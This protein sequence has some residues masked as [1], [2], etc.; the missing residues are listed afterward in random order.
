[1]RSS[2]LSFLVGFLAFLLDIDYLFIYA[3]AFFLLFLRTQLFPVLLRQTMHRDSFYPEDVI[4]FRLVLVD[5]S[6]PIE[7]PQRPP[8]SLAIVLIACLRCSLVRLPRMQQTFDIWQ[9]MVVGF[10]CIGH[11]R[12]RWSD[13]LRRRLNRF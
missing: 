7:L 12:I 13:T 11:R 3:L 9:R 10:H 8:K 2:L 1:M 4:F 5:P 6:V